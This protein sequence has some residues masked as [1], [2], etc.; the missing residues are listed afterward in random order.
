MPGA[1]GEGM[2]SYWLI[3]TGLQFGKIRRKE[4]NQGGRPEKMIMGGSQGKWSEGPVNLCLNLVKH[5]Y[6]QERNAM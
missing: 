3:G 4:L 2:G 6:R 5:F 1:G